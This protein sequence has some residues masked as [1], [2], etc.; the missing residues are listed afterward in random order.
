MEWLYYLE[1]IKFLMHLG[2][3]CLI[4]LHVNLCQRASSILRLVFAF[5]DGQGPWEKPVLHPQPAS[6]LKV[7]ILEWIP[8]RTTTPPEMG[9]EDQPRVQASWDAWQAGTPGPGAT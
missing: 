5:T 6:N 8:F 2:F 1:I 3:P 4:V 7:S 9:S